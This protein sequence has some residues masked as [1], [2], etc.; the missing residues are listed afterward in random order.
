MVSEGRDET[1]G[2]LRDRLPEDEWVDLPEYGVRVKRW[3]DPTE[4]WRAA[5]ALDGQSTSAQL[6]EAQAALAA[7]QQDLSAMQ[8]QRDEA[9]AE[10]AEM[11]AQRNRLAERL[12]HV[13]RELAAANH[14][15]R[16]V[17]A[18]LDS[19]LSRL[20]EQR[21]WQVARQDTGI[22]CSSCS[23]PIVR[24]QAFQPLADAKGFFSHCAC[25]DKES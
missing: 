17:N 20:N 4:T 7:S 19:A 3:A 1:I 18:E 13:G 11:R 16:R 10:A 5:L 6:R 23:G 12:D 15:K 21:S 2:E 25:P 14:A 22:T 9:R 24:G 8:A